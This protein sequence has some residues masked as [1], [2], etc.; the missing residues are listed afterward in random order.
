[1][2]ESPLA[3]RR[4]LVTRPAGRQQELIDAIKARGGE[5]VSLPLLAIEPID[6]PIEDPRPSDSKNDP[7]RDTHRDPDP[8]RDTHRE[9][10][11]T[12]TRLWDAHLLDTHRELRDE[13]RDTRNSTRESKGRESKG[14]THATRLGENLSR[15]PDYEILIFV[16]ANAV[17]FG[18]RKI[19]ECGAEISPAAA[20]LAV[21]AATAREAATL[22]DLAVH[23]PP[24][25]SGSEQLLK[26][27]QL[28]DVQDRRIAIFRGQG[29]RELLAAELRRRGAFVDYIEVYRRV[30][31][32]NAA[33]QLREILAEGPLDMVIVTSAEAL[34]RWR[35][36]TDEI[37]IAAHDR[38]PDETAGTVPNRSPSGA[39]SAKHAQNRSF[40]LPL[41]AKEGANE[42]AK[43]LLNIPIAAPSRRVAE[44]AAQHGF[45]VVIDAGDAGANAMAEALAAYSRRE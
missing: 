10:G 34:A 12:R 41:Q 2:N 8:A 37:T 35:E 16:S 6:P 3:G 21:G 45:S 17:R 5:P 19:A 4:I 42:I 13:L 36:L 9:M 15:L 38:S 24:V 28:K 18:A 39:Q 31:A 11:D 23:G 14:D 20:V 32:A 33:G 7:I 44:L 1:M 30:P 25:G 27:P 26:L 29:G 43:Q 40:A 22:L